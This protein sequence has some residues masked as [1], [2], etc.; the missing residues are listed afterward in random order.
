MSKRS[1]KTYLDVVGAMGSAQA[2]RL[3]RD[4]APVADFAELHALDFVIDALETLLTV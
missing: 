4:F 1:L 3:E 2:A